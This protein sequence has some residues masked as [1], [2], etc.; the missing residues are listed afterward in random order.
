MKINTVALKTTNLA[1]YYYRMQAVNDEL[2]FQRVIT[3]RK[4]N[5]MINTEDENTFIIH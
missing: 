4:E 1:I 3:K 5:A 2:Q